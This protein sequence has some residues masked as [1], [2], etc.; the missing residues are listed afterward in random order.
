MEAK[1]VVV[2]EE[3][4]EVVWLRKF[5]IGLGLMPLVVQPMIL[6]CDNSRAMTQSKKQMNHQKSKHTT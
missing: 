2:F 4:K 1:Y 5:F 6:F 3:A